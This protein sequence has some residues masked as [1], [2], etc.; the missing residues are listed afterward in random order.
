[1]ITK[2]PHKFKLFG[3]HHTHTASILVQDAQ[4]AVVFT[5][6]FTIHSFL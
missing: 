1:M 4:Q 2:K 5:R 6:S 3:C